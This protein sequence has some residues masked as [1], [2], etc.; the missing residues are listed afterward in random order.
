MKY[1]YFSP[2]EFNHF[3]KM[4]KD[5]LDWL[6][7]VRVNY[8]SSWTIKG[9]S[10]YRKYDPNKG[11][12]QMHS[13]GRA[14]DFHT[15]PVGMLLEHTQRLISA[16]TGNYRLGVYPY[17]NNPGFHIDNHSNTR[18]WIRDKSGIYTYY[19]KSKDLLQGLKEHL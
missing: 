8:G 5:F 4:D 19:S 12:L 15:N 13:K 2:D 7:R 18:Y 11:G 9:H 1:Q 10:D 17:W 3:D 16:L 14:L 6:H